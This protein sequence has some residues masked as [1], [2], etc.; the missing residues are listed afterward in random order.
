MDDFDILQLEKAPAPAAERVPSSDRDRSGG[1]DKD[2][3]SGKKR[4]REEQKQ[5]ARSGKAEKSGEKKE[6]R[7]GDDN[8]PRF[9]KAPSMQLDKF[10]RA[11]EGKEVVRDKKL[12]T[13]LQRGDKAAKEAAIAAARGEI[14]LTEEAGCVT[15]ET[16]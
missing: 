16:P 3:T 2:A 11:K 12:K 15:A 6:R 5:R 13:T 14:L 1:G 8:E 9:G 4:R 10:R 7:D